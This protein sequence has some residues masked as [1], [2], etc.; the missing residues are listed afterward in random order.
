MSQYIVEIVQNEEKA[1]LQFFEIRKQRNMYAT[2][3]MEVREEKKFDC[4]STDILTVWKE[5]KQIYSIVE[6]DIIYL[7]GKGLQEKVWQDLIDR[8]EVFMTPLNNREI[9]KIKTY[10]AHADQTCLISLDAAE[11]IKN[12]KEES[13]FYVQSDGKI[14]LACGANLQRAEE[15]RLDEEEEARSSGDD[16]KGKEN[17]KNGLKESVSKPPTSKL[18][19]PKTDVLKPVSTP[20]EKLPRCDGDDVRE[21]FEQRT[22]NHCTTENHER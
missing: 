11:Y 4:S 13:G 10:L 3:V 20:E 22:A 17:K 21:Y 6:D 18:A 9:D 16:R 1:S 8:L 15:L 12:G 2:A 7:L 14:I 19:A 5:W